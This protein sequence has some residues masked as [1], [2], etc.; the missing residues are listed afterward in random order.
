MQMSENIDKWTKGMIAFRQKLTQPSKT[1]ENPFFKSNYVT[2]DGIVKSADDAIKALGES[3]G[4]VYSQELSSDV[5]AGVVSVTTLVSH[6]SGQYVMFGPLQVVI[7]GKHDAQAAGS[8]GT[9]AKRYALSAALG[10][11][12]DID[13]DGNG[14]SMNKSNQSNNSYSNRS[15]SNQYQTKK[16]TTNFADKK[17]N[18]AKEN[19]IID[20]ITQ[21]SELFEMDRKEFESSLFN[22]YGVPTV[23]DISNAIGDQMIT[24]LSKGIEQGK[25]AQLSNQEKE[26]KKQAV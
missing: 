17:I 20:M 13:D 23:K 15:N 24:Y 6:E 26:N 4:I 11:T 1:A 16:P 18:K 14:A 22:K 8:A 2:L 10:I 5:N 3:C 21:A 7:T 25:Q 9:Y 12:S 19:Q